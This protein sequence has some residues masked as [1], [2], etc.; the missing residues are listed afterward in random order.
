MSKY[1]LD[2]SALLVLLNRETGHEKV[3]E[4]LEESAISAVNLAEVASKLTD[5]GLPP[6][7]FRPELEALGLSVVPFDE[8]AAYGAAAMRPVTRKAGLSLGD[9]ACLGTS[10]AL[11]VTAVTADQSWTKVRTGVKVQLLR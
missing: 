10:L 9:R 1:L 11:G 7:T 3:T 5:S 6:A 8:E 2:A 4:I